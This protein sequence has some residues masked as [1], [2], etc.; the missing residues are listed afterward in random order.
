MRTIENQAFLQTYIDIET[1]VFVKAEKN[2]KFEEIFSDI[3][4]H[5][6]D[7]SEVV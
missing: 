7:F 5:N 6:K 2:K 3:K 1:K 4:T